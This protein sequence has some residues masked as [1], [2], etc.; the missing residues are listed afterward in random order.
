[1]GNG[2]RR[3]GTIPLLGIVDARADETWFRYPSNFKAT[4]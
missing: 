1:L 4:D 2:D 3:A